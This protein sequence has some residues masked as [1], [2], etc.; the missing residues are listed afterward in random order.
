MIKSCLGYSISTHFTINV[1]MQI[2]MIKTVSYVSNL[3]IMR[4][5]GNKY[6][7]VVNQNAK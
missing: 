4:R 3:M 7:L 1:L 6:M 2:N 5:A